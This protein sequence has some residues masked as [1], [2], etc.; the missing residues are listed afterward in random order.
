MDKSEPGWFRRS[1]VEEI[2]RAVQAELGDNAGPASIQAEVRQRVT[3]YLGSEEF[4]E[5]RARQRREELRLSSGEP[6][7]AI[8]DVLIAHDPAWLIAIGA[9]PEQYAIEA[10]PLSQRLAH[11]DSREAVAQEVTAVLDHYFHRWDADIEQLS[12]DIWEAWQRAR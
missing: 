2:A 3:A 6:A 5:R 10:A 12:A 9:P 1:I 7:L 11:V 4:Q 8:L